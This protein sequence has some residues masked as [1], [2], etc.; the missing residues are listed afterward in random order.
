V[1]IIGAGVIGC[2]IAY[3]LCKHGLT[4]VIL[5]EKDEFPGCGS[6]SK[7]NGGIRAQF[8]TEANIRMSLLSMELLDGMDEEM[9]AQSGYVKAGYLFVTAVPE[10][11]SQLRRNIQL[12]RNLGVD[13]E[14]LSPE[15]IRARFPYVKSDDLVGGS[16]GGRD[17]FIDP[18]GLTNAFYSGARNLGARV[19][20]DTAA[21]G[22]I[23]SNGRVS[24]VETDRGRVEAEWVVN[25]AGAHAAKVAAWAGLEL[26][27][28][29]FRSN[30][31]VTGPT[32]ELPRRIPMTIDMDTGLLIRR[33]G[34]GCALAWTDPKEPPGFDARFDST[35]LE[36]IAPKIERRF[37]RLAEAGIDFSHCWAGLYPE[38]PDHHAIL[39]ESGVRGFLLATGLGGHGIMHAPAVGFALSELICEG[40]VTRIDL[41]P[42]DLRRFESGQLNPEGAVL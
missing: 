31:A 26:P 3:Y 30:I 11:S 25:A 18:G 27:V 10:N 22:L 16:F 41:S 36:K 19:L 23:R 13:V 14:F 37:P 40:N 12:Q 7:A 8:T 20:L 32:P 28:S 35:F 34:R 5:I 6:T 2:S 42:F 29:P 38:T 21:T 33:E 1:A 24:G 9:R 4:D 15:E 17:G 39:G